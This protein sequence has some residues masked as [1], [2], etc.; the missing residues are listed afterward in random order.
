VERGNG[1]LRDEMFVSGKGEY[2]CVTHC[3]N[4]EHTEKIK[5]GVV[6]GGG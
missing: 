2:V 5:W 1:I 6:G 4:S 3:D